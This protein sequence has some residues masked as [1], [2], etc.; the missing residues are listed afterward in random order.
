MTQVPT[1]EELRRMSPEK[2]AATGVR[3]MD[4]CE[5]ALSEMSGFLGVLD[6]AQGLSVAFVN[7]D[8]A[9]H[10]LRQTEAYKRRY[11]RT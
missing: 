8:L 9:T 11:P 5:D 3:L 7:L 10:R 2:L 4:A 6:V 1:F